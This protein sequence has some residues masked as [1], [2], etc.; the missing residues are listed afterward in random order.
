MLLVVR[1]VLWCFCVDFV[2]D[3]GVKPMSVCWNL[4]VF[5]FVECEERSGMV[6]FAVH[7]RQSNRMLVDLEGPHKCENYCFQHDI[8][9]KSASAYMF[10]IKWCECFLEVKNLCTF[11][12]PSGLMCAQEFKHVSSLIAHGIKYHRIYL[13]AFCK[14]KFGSVK[15]LEAHI[16]V[17]AGFV[18]EGSGRVFSKLF[19]KLI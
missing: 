2:Y 15:E 8:Q 9:F 18:H 13:C 17:T 6:V 7:G 5:T 16:H 3:V 4:C 10:H 14:R 11:S 19:V 12:D 1:L